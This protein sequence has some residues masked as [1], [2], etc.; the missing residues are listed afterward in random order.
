MSGEKRALLFWV[1]VFFF[2]FILAGGAYLW[3]K[4]HPQP[5]GKPAR[6]AHS[7]PPR[8]TPQ[9]V[10]SGQYT[11]QTNLTAEQAAR[12]IPFNGPFIQAFEKRDFAAMEQNLKQG[13]NINVL[14]P[15]GW[16]V[17]VGAIEKG[18]R[19]MIRFLLTH[20][21]DINS[22]SLHGTTPL[23]AA[24]RIHDVDLVRW[25]LSKGAQVNQA[26]SRQHTPLLEA[27][28]S[29]VSNTFLKM[30]FH[31]QK[32]SDEQLNELNESVQIV[33]TLLQHGA[34]V[35][36]KAR[37]QVTALIYLATQD[38]PN[39]TI[40]DMLL[41]AGAKVNEADANGNTP[42]MFAALKG[43][44]PLLRTLLQNNADPEQQNKYGIT[45]LMLA[46]GGGH[47]A[48]VQELLNWHTNPNI[49]DQEGRTALLWALE[50]NLYK[51]VETQVL[52]NIYSVFSYDVGRDHN[53]ILEALVTHGANL[54]H[55]DRQGRAVLDLIRQTGT[56][57]QVLL[58]RAEAWRQE[59][60]FKD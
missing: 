51:T 21:A 12:A 25:L 42:L 45:P 34:D 48:P 7:Q 19:D 55:K 13:A 40:A 18:D 15:N 2:L 17:L 44:M 9:P 35:H 5:Q 14:H 20:G 26:D 32:L 52:A 58:K 24:V 22:R 31:D 23:I 60:H 11:P 27:V 49:H 1:S 56:S 57:E 50:S 38:D 46:A 30:R 8:P 6:A 37:G 43:E 54:N 59:H 28:R 10:S 29:A 39:L 41:K 33:R 16:P 53:Q 47:I 36:H 3:Q 4:N